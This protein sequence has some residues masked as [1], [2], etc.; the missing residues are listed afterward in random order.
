[1][2]VKGARREGDG[3]TRVVV[4]WSCLGGDLV[5][6]FKRWS[7]KGLR[8][9]SSSTDP[10]DKQHMLG[11]NDIDD[12]RW[13]CSLTESELDLLVGLKNLVHLRAKKIG[14]EDLAK[15][16]DLRMLRTLSFNFMENLQ[17]RLKD[18]PGAFGSNILNHNLSGDFGS[19]T[20]EDLY[21]F[22]CS[23]KKK[24]IADI[25]KLQFCVGRICACLMGS[26]GVQ[27]LL[28]VIFVGNAEEADL[29]SSGLVCKSKA[30]D[31]QLKVCKVVT[32]DQ[33]LKPRIASCH[34]LCKKILRQML[35]LYQ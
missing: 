9:G 29:V 3:H 20:I 2:M 1:M 31:W 4:G 30:E 11:N 28:L 16:F 33:P 7:R 15:K 21:P 24:R 5:V 19:M 35:K 27:K 25:D 13:L 6:G 8:G 10:M 18:L 12:V 34:S 14:H 23:D 17:G 22:I 26:D 32:P